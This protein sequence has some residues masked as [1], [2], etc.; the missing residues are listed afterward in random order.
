MILVRTEEGEF[1]EGKK[2]GL[3]VTYDPKT[4]K[5]LSQVEYAN[6]VE[7]KR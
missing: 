1:R 2:H 7:R 6:G 3:W 5:T 4:G